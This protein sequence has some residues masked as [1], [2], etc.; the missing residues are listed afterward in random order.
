MHITK[1]KL[2]DFIGQQSRAT[3]VNFLTVMDPARVVSLMQFSDQIYKSKRDIRKIAV[4]SGS[5]DEPE[6]GFCPKGA[7][8]DLL[9]FEDFPDLFD[10]N[11]D[12]SGPEWTKYHRKYDLVL[13]EQVLEHC[14]NPGRAI[15]NL[16]VLLKTSGVLHISVPAV[17][18]THGEPHYFYAGFSTS[19]L[20]AFSEESGLGVVECESWDSDKGSRMYSTC[21]WAPLAQSGPLEFLVKAISLP[22]SGATTPF[23]STLIGRVRNILIYPFQDLFSKPKRNNAVI[24]WL[25]AVKQ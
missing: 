12:W 18:N 3:Q 4:V 16:A 2:L 13:C 11:L 5:Y 9:T 8:V 15:K 24:T 21:D 14:L 23:L 10:L 17:N 22:R 25:V 19:T 6:L 1:G 7:V 20:R